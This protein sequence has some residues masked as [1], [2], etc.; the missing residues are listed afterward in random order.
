M[1]LFNFPNTARVNRVIPKNA[2][3]DY[4]NTRQKKQFADL[5]SKITWTHKLSID[6][7]N[8]T[9]KEVGE[10]QVFRLELKVKEDVKSLLEIIDKSIPYPIIFVVTYEEGVYL[11]TSVKHPHPVNEN[12]SII[13][14]TFKSDWFPQTENRYSITLKKNLDTV[15]RD[16]CI[17]LSDTPQLAN[18]S[19]D[20]VINKSK[21]VQ[22]LRTEI[23]KLKSAISKSRQFNQKVEMN[24]R[25]KEVEAQLDILTQESG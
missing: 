23:S 9:G 24:M 19:L 16:F 4:T 22:K 7:I 5:V 18:E 14:W 3:D 6:T 11:S 17:Q 20:T 13:D 2:F 25:L 1:D 21:E 12:N 8:L 10:I 15:Y